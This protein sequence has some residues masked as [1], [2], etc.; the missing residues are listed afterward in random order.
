M[1]AT[2]VHV[3][4]D[5]VA[6]AFPLPLRRATRRL[7]WA[8]SFAFMAL[9]FLTA[10]DQGRGRLSDGV[11]SATISLPMW[12]FWVPVVFGT[13]LSALACLYHL[14][15]RPAANDRTS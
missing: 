15:A 3:S 10:L 14:V 2:G 5:V 6:T 11:V 8:F 7:G 12:W 4:V 13:G 1:N 9:C